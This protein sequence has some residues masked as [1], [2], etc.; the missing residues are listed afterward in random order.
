[1]NTRGRIG[2]AHL[3]WVL[4]NLADGRVVNRISVPVAVPDHARVALMRMIAIKTDAGPTLTNACQANE[5]EI[6]D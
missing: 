1:M 2:L 6:G 3:A 4:D 5:N